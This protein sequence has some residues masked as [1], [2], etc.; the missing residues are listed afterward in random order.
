[1][2]LGSLA[3]DLR[4]ADIM[5]RLLFFVAFMAIS[6]IGLCS[7]SRGETGIALTLEDADRLAQLPLKCMQREFPNKPGET[8]ALPADIG[9]PQNLHPA[10][11]GC[12]DW[13]SSVHGHW[14]LVSLNPSKREPYGLQSVQARLNE[15]LFLISGPS[16]TYCERIGCLGCIEKCN[17]GA[18]NHD[19]KP[20]KNDGLR[21]GC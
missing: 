1:M 20:S 14:M 17:A 8:L 21:L 15:R 12:F 11:Y 16:T 13:H 7:G 19:V 2:S 10:F 5:K 6:S 3:S 9:S 18:G 4:G